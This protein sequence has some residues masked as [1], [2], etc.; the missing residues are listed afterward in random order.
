VYGFISAAVVG[1]VATT[2]EYATLRGDIAANSTAVAANRE[3]LMELK[4]DTNAAIVASEA[5][6][7]AS[8]TELKSDTNAA[9]AA[10]EGR[11]SASIAASVAGA[12]DS[13]ARLLAALQ[14][15]KWW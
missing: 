13:E 8:M 5:R 4:S 3:A 15:K 10:S 7:S 12:K 2:F 11:L 1:G 6:L 14:A 9:I